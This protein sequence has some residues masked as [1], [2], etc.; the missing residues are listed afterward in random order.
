MDAKFVGFVGFILG[1]VVGG[2]CTFF[3]VQDKFDKRLEKEI[4]EFKA[5]YVDDISV[6]STSDSDSE[7]VDVSNDVS[8]DDENFVAQIDEVILPQDIP[9]AAID[10]AAAMNAVVRDGGRNERTDY[11]KAVVEEG[12]MMAEETGKKPYVITADDYFNP[13][14]KQAEYERK[15][16]YYDSESGEIY[17]EDGNYLEDTDSSIGYFN[18]TGISE[19]NQ[20]TV[21][22]CNEA[23][24]MLYE[25]C[26]DDPV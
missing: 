5:F 8:E 24:G 9:Q 25:V 26:N 19:G 11:T 17:D 12:Y 4:A 18:C 10:A 1:T 3:A 14:G 6:K 15:R 16:V 22:V 21:F 20:N 7:N 23:E 13:M 2:L